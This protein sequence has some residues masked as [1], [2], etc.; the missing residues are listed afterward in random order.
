MHTGIKLSAILPDSANKDL[1]SKG[2]DLNQLM[3][4]DIDGLIF[5]IGRVPGE[6]Q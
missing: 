1:E 4:T 5:R 3:Q 6:H 2:V